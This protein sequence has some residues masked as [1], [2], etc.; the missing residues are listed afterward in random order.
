MSIHVHA[1]AL[2]ALGLIAVLP[3]AAALAQQ[4]ETSSNMDPLGEIIITATRVAQPANRALESLVLIDRDALENSLA[5]DVGE[6][7]HCPAIAERGSS[8]QGQLQP[9]PL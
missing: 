9:Y 3:A 2:R 8:R 4:S 1:R 5:S 7:R 6:H